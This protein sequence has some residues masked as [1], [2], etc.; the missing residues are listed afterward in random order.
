MSSMMSL[1]CYILFGTH[2]H[3]TGVTDSPLRILQGGHY[4]WIPSSR[5]PHPLPPLPTCPTLLVGTCGLL[6]PSTQLA[7]ERL[8]TGPGSQVHFS[9]PTA[10]WGDGQDSHLLVGSVL[11]PSGLPQCCATGKQELINQ[12]IS[13][14]IN[15]LINQSIN[16]SI[17]QPINQP[18]MAIYQ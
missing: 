11:Q 16:Q 5:W 7:S 15:Q 8:G 4:S 17:N 9:G 6:F 13:Q 12:S 14:S 1:M 3:T 10:D 18:M 2:T